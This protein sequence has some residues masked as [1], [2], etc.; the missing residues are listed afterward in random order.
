MTETE[1]LRAIAAVY[2]REPKPTTLVEQAKRIVEIRHILRQ[3][4]GTIQ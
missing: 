3:L 2:C 4:K 1:V